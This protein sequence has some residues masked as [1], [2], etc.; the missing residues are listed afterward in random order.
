MPETTNVEIRLPERDFSGNQLP[1]HKGSGDP[2]HSHSVCWNCEKSI[3][4]EDICPSCVRVQPFGPE[5]NYYDI[6]DIPE[7]LLLDPRLLI[8]AYHEKSRTF[9]PDH[10]V[11]DSDKEQS[12]TLSN[13][14]L[15]NLAFRTLRDPFSRAHYFI[16]RIKGETGRLH[17]KTAMSPSDLMEIMDLKEELESTVHKGGAR[18]AEQR[19]RLIV[20]PLER[21]IF[22][23]FEKID[24]LLET[25]GKSSGALLE[26]LA[27]LESRLEKRA[28]LHNLLREIK[29]G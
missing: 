18:E 2:G 16:G 10:H 20:Y 3:E 14:S 9:H 13:T 12:I 26:S 19:L 25:E 1:I 28:Y 7:K 11:G 15:L 6:L 4:K 8:A 27:G 24:R 17:R 21:E 23:S 5:R 29:G 22:D